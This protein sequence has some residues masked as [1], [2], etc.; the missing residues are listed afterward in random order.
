MKLTKTDQNKWISNQLEFL[1]PLA[2]A[3]ATAYF[4][5]ILFALGQSD[6]VVSLADFVPS[7]TVITLIVFYIINALYDLIRKW[8]SNAK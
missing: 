4:A 7:N 8:A 1:K 6:H 2:L 3:V 5:P